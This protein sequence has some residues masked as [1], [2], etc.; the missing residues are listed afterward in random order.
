MKSFCIKCN[1]KQLNNYLLKSFKNFKLDNLYVSNKRFKIY[2]NIILHYINTSNNNSDFYDC[3]CEILTD[4][5][6]E[7]YEKNELKKIINLNYFYFSKIEQSIILKDC[8]KYINDYN[9]LEHFTRREHI[10]IS[11]LKYIDEN[12]FFILDGFVNFRLAQYKKILEY[13]VDTCVNNFLIEKEYNEFISLLR[14]YINSNPSN[15]SIL[16]LLYKNKECVLL[17]SNYNEIPTK[18]YCLDAKYLSDISFSLNDYAFNSLLTLL[19]KKL[20]IHLIDSEDEFIETLK[21]I[22]DKRVSICKHC[23][24]CTKYKMINKI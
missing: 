3:F 24:L 7:F 21:L 10:Y 18:D 9:N 1:N 11:L 16:H 5:I 2:N 8:L 14:I 6:I 20:N 19:P 12:K 15:C 4:A 22:F 13:V 17:D 23:S